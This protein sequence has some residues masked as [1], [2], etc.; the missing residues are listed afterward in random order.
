ML[1]KWKVLLLASFFSFSVFAGDLPANAFKPTPPDIAAKAYLLVDAKTGYVIAENNANER[2]EPASLTKML[3]AYIVE[4]EISKGMVSPND[5]TTVSENAWAKNFPGSSLMFIRVGTQVSIHDLLKGV[6]ISS[7]NDATV[8]LAEHIS[9]NIETFADLMNEHAKR[10]GMTSS[11]FMNPHGLPDP[12]HYTTAHDLATLARAI[13]YEYPKQYETY[14]EKSFMYNNINQPNR[15][16]LLWSDSS[17]DG[18]K[19]GH[20]SSAGYCLVASAKREDMRLISVVMGTKSESARAQETQKLLSYGYRFY[21]TSKALLKG[22]KVADVKVWG[23]VSEKIDVVA[24][25]DLYITALKTNA[26]A[27]NKTDVVLNKPIKAPLTK[28][29]VLGEITVTSASGDVYKQAIVAGEDIP[30]SGFFSRN[31]DFFML[32]IFSLFS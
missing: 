13:I 5:L 3:T 28:G 29:D 20:T 25:E 9:G 10:L 27:A 15:N 21:K 12:N 30:Q 8:A 16:R 31:W 24:S 7:G 19:T 11:H 22:D 23:G 14:S 26:A 6:I 4:Y 18:L 32:F 1:V 2:V 17:V